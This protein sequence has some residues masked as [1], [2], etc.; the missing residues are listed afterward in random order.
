MTTPRIYK[1]DPL[2]PDSALRFILEKSGQIFD[3]FIAKV[4][5]QAMGIYPVGTVVDLDTGERAVV[6]Q[7]ERVEPVHPPSR[8]SSRSAVTARSIREG[9]STTSPRKVPGE[10]GYRRTIVRTVYDIEAERGKVQ[11][12]TTE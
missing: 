10:R 8:L 9:P 4:F 5:I 3:P 12:F 6:V 1:I 11:F 2:T 7:T